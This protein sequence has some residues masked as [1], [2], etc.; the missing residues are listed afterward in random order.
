VSRVLRRGR[1]R[2]GRRA[3]RRVRWARK[4]RAGRWR[5]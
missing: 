1:S 4:A 5:C 2:G 3:A